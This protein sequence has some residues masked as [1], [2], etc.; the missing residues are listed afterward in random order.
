MYYQIYV[1]TGHRKRHAATHSHACSACYQLR[2]QYGTLDSTMATRRWVLMTED[3][4]NDLNPREQ[5]VRR[6]PFLGVPITKLGVNRELSMTTKHIDPH[7]CFQ[8]CPMGS[9]INRDVW[10]GIA[11]YQKVSIDQW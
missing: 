2:V 11:I 7:R 3:A 9:T 1:K 10:S 4:A 8:M 6:L 5:I